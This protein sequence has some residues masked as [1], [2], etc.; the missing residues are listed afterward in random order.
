MLND[1]L[2]HE[3]LLPKSGPNLEEESIP[4]GTPGCGKT[5][6]TPRLFCGV[7]NRDSMRAVYREINI[8][9]AAGL[10]DF[11]ALVFI[12]K[13]YNRY[14]PDCFEGIF[15]KTSD[16]HQHD[17]QARGDIEIPRSVSNRSSVSII[18]RAS[19]LWNK[20]STG[21]N[22]LDNFNQFK[23]ELRLEL[24]DKYTFETH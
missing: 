4:G 10:R 3:S 15:C 21:A 17:T 18:Y 19:K 8:I 5:R 23:S 20:L 22:E 14:L 1:V 7:V 6:T 11:Y 9:P 2:K 16:V 12:Y 24:L 13:Y